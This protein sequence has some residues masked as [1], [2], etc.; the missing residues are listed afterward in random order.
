MGLAACTAMGRAATHD[1]KM[2]QH[3][4]RQAER[5]KRIKAIENKATQATKKRIKSS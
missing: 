2:P 1:S 5:D 4:T 3:H